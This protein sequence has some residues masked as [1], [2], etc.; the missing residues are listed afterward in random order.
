M[1]YTPP[2]YINRHSKDFE[3][4]VFTGQLP[5]KQGQSTKGRAT[6]HSLAKN[7]GQ[8]SKFSTIL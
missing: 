6:S 1:G 2:T 8:R 4:E 7:V 3:A 5:N